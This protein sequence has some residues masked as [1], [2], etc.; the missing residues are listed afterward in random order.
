MAKIRTARL[1]IVQ[2]RKYIYIRMYM[3]YATRWEFTF[4]KFIPN[5]ESSIVNKNKRP[6]WEGYSGDF[7]EVVIGGAAC[8]LSWGC[9]KCWPKPLL[10]FGLWLLAFEIQLSAFGFRLT[11][12]HNS[13]ARSARAVKSKSN[14]Y[15]FLINYPAKSERSHIVNIAKF[16]VHRPLNHLRFWDKRRRCD[17]FFKIISP[18]LA[19]IKNLFVLILTRVQFVKKDFYIP[20]LQWLSLFFGCCFS[21]CWQ[22]VLRHVCHLPNVYPLLIWPPNFQLVNRNCWGENLCGP[23]SMRNALQLMPTVVGHPFHLE[24]PARFSYPRKRSFI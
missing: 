19:T 7:R 1:F 21:A 3:L 15:R 23:G 9:Q 18:S 12:H 13:R 4:K 24:L 22:N 2:F 5:C 11:K 10:A 8:R 16:P 6:R 14:S 20:A 17:N